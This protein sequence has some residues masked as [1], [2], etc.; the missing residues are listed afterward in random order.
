[1]DTKKYEVFVKTAEL[2]SLTRAGA[3]L[4]LTQ[5]GVS[6][7]LAGLEG[8]LGFPLLTRSRTGARL[9]PE[10]ERALPLIREILRGQAALDAL[11]AEL[12]QVAEGTVRVGTFTSVA[13]HWL[14]GMMQAF[15][16]KYPRVDFKLFNGDYHDVDRWL[17]DGSV[18]LAFTALPLRQ[19]C[20]AIALAEDRLLAI[21]PPGHPLA[22]QAVCPTEELVR[23]PFITL[24]ESSD[25]DSRRA[26]EKA[27]VRPDVRFTTKDDYAII[28]M[29]SQG[30]GVSIMPELLLEGRR[31]GIEVRPLDPPT[32]RTIALALPAGD[33]TGPAARTFADF[34]VAWVKARHAAG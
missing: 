24:L 10:G 27:G 22:A 28:A 18:D 13:V 8:E 5:S 32:S 12:R 7:V 30:M 6:H 21:L 2:A 16:E 20:P 19:R 4:G 26:L 9:T 1:M 31:D 14:P 17:T 25:H 3:E 34:A 15:Q 29:V 11:A 23:W 33:R